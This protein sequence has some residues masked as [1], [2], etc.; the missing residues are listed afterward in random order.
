M[1]VLTFIMAGGRGKRLYPLTRDRAKPAVPFGGIYRIIDFTLSNCVNSNLRQIFVLTQYKSISLFQHLKMAW[2]YFSREFNEFID[3]I[4]AHQTEK[5]EKWYQGTADAI[6]QNIELISLFNPAYILVLS[7]DHIYKMDYRRM[8]KFHKEKNAD[9]TI[10]IIEMPKE[11]SH[12]FG[13]L[14]IN[15][16]DEVIGFEEKPKNPKTILNKEDKCYISMGVYIFKTDAL[17]EKLKEDATNIETSHDFGKNIIP[18]MV[19]TNKVFAFPFIDEN[20]KEIQ[21]WRDIG[22]LS[23][24]WEANMDLVNVDP[25]LN[26]Y[27]NEWP[28]YTYH[29]QLPP[30]KTVFG[31]T[32]NSRVGMALNSLVSSGC[33]ISGGTVQKSILSPNVKINSYCDIEESIIMDGAEIGRYSKIKKT[34]IDKNVYIPPYSVIGHNLEEDKKRFFVSKE[35]IVVIPKIQKK[36]NIMEENII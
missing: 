22:T 35:G 34:I 9:V 19:S 10:G 14:E 12:E 4:P 2:N 20:K 27:D 29:S 31:E 13:I 24:Y 7:G 11:K 23:A 16:K 6:Y 17:L 26:L 1:E 15:E 3:L 28:I 8:L 33:I 5:E 21:Y 36:E 32:G 30:S 18:N 25:V